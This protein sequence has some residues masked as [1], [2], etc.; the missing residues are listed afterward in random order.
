MQEI[1]T[2]TEEQAAPFRATIT[3]HLCTDSRHN[4]PFSQVKLTHLP[5]QAYPHDGGWKVKGSPGL[6]W[7]YIVCPECEYEWAIYKLGVPRDFDST[8]TKKVPE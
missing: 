1:I 4:P 2:L 6:W 7:V 8:D 5:I 3:K